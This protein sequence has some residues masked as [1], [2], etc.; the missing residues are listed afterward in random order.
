MVSSA[1][2]IKREKYDAYFSHFHIYLSNILLLIVELVLST[3]TLV[4]HFG[5]PGQVLS[6]FSYSSL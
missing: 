6:N 4:I 3:M 2:Y 1:L 5:Y